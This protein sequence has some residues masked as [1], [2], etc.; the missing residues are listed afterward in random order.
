VTGVVIPN[1]GGADP[2]V[3]NRLAALEAQNAMYTTPKGYQQLTSTQLQT[4][5][6][7]TVPSGA[8][9]AVMQSNGV[10]A[11]RWRDDGQSPSASTGNG[12]SASGQRI[13]AGGEKD[14]TGTL[15]AVRVIGEGAGA[16]LDIAYYG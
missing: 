7:L 14:Y 16:V 2:S 1:S 15:S 5:Q 11:V 3:N 9:R 13:E 6:S 10:Q 12:D 4:V 8:M